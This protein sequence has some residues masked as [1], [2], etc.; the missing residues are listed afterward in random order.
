MDKPHLIG[1]PPIALFIHR[2]RRAK[3]FSLR[4]SNAD[5]KVS[6]T[7]PGRSSLRDA[8]DFAQRQVG[9]L[10]KNLAARLPGMTPEFGG[11][12]PFGGRDL[13]L[14]QSTERHIRIQD[15]A[16]LM[17]GTQAQLGGRLR[18]FCK[19]Q[20]REQLV[21]ASQKYADLLGVNFCRITLRDTRSRWGSCTEAGNL[22]Y[23]WRLIMAPPLVLDYV[24]AHEVAHLKELN[25][26]VAYWQ[27]VR[28]ICPDFQDHRGWLRKHG[29]QL[30]QIIFD[31]GVDA[32]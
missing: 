32:L 12:F 17:P 29:N 25:H 26:S 23:S 21:A 16:L 20:A 4:I 8:L 1:T 19:V 22:M 7:V 30:H 15:D 9:W 3:K 27:Q 18:G 13:R 11:S 10:Q 28:R 6:L 31:A 24:A 2:S 5:G 14:V